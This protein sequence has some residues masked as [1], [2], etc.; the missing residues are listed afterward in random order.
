MDE[1]EKI[2]VV[3]Q[4]CV[5]LGHN[6]AETTIKL[7]TAYGSE[8]PHRNTISKWWHF[9]KSGGT[10]TAADAST[11]RPPNPVNQRLLN[12]ITTQLTED[13]KISLSLLSANIGEPKGYLYNL[14][15]TRLEFRKVVA[16]W[17]PK[18][19]TNEQK[20]KRVE[21]AKS[22][23][24]HYGDD[25]DDFLSNL[26]TVD[27]T[28][29][30]YEPSET[31]RTASAWQL[32]GEK[33]PEVGRISNMR[34]KTMATVFWNKKGIVHIDYLKT[35]K[36]INSEYYCSLL[37]I[38][39]SKI[40]SRKRS[41]VIFLQDNCPAHKAKITKEKIANFRWTLLDH[42]PYS[43][44]LAPSDFFLFR[45]LKNDLLKTRFLDYEDVEMKVSAYFESKSSD[46]FEGGLN[47]FKTQLNNVILNKGGFF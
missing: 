34:K 12:E 31:Q 9:F 7:Q 38:V 23:L 37:D 10:E 15:Q 18:V 46:W 20:V 40:P 36:S 43:P 1:N 28:W 8:A 4:F 25:W 29:V 22:L 42:P 33:P 24:N 5:K 27:E 14:I 11:G 6:L 44:D 13:P 30:Y 41:K 2:R 35:G 17:V 26:L 45:N 3:I 21:N 39:Q 32:P 47:M 16:K 19:L